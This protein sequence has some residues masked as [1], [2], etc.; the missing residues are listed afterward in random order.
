MWR[1]YNHNNKHDSFDKTNDGDLQGAGS[2][3]PTDRAGPAL[4]MITNFVQ[5]QKYSIP[6]A[7]SHERQP[8]LPQ[9]TVIFFKIFPRLVKWSNRVGACDFVIEFREMMNFHQK[10]I[11]QE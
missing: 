6:L 9:F 4:Q 11:S 1:T 5:Q 3:V 10:K 8:L 7:F 2:M